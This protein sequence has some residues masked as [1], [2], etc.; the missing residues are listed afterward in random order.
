MASKTGQKRFFTLVRKNLLDLEHQRLLNFVN[1]AI[2]AETT[3]LISVWVG[4][5]AAA[6]K[7][8]MEMTVF[9]LVFL[10]FV[11]LSLYQRI[12]QVKRKIE[13]L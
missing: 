3:L 11:L 9:S 6:A 10:I 2:I 4:S 5:F 13:Q 7:T 8:K 12:D 1:I